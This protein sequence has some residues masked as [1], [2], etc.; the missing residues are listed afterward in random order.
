MMRAGVSISSPPSPPELLERES[1]VK[2]L[3]ILADA[4]LAAQ[5]F[6]AMVEGPPGIGKTSLLA[7][8]AS[9][10]SR[11]G[12]TPLRARGVELEQEFSFGVALQLLDP[13][14]RRASA[15][16]RDELF[17]DAAGVVRRLFQPETAAQ[18]AGSYDDFA[19][20]HGLYWLVAGLSEHSPLLVVVDDLQWADRPSL[21]FLAFLA[22]RLDGLRVAV[23][24]AGRTGAGTEEDELRAQL[25]MTSRFVLRPQ[26]LSATAVANL[27]RRQL[28][29]VDPALYDACAAATGGNPF[30]V[31]ALVEE[32]AASQSPV[33]AASVEQ[34]SPRIVSG[35]LLRRLAALPASALAVARAA[36]VLGDG[37]T[38]HEVATV[39][40][41]DAEAA[42]GAAAAL[43]QTE[44]LV[45]GNRLSYTHP[46]ARN[47][48]YQDLPE[49][50]RTRLHAIAAQVLRERGARVRQV[51]AQVLL[52]GPG[53]IPDAVGILE[54]AAEEALARGAPEVA[55]TYLRRTL[56]E[57]I[58]AL[59]R[60][61][62][63]G[64]LGQAA[65]RAG[66][67]DAEEAL[68]A[69]VELAQTA[70]QH[71]AAALDLARLNTSRGSSRE[72]IDVLT[73]CAQRCALAAPDLLNRLRAE[74]MAI[75][76]VDLVVRDR[77]EAA[78]AALPAGP[79]DVDPTVR[80]M[81]LAHMATQA[82]RLCRSADEAAQLARS[83]LEG[84][85]LVA[86]GIA[87]VQLSFLAAYFLICADRFAEA[88]GVFGSMLLAAHRAG[89]PAGFASASAWRSYGY[90]RQGNLLAAE[91]DAR[92]ALD[93]ARA[94]GLKLVEHTALTTLCWTL[95][96]RGE[97]DE[98]TRVMDQAP[99]NLNSLQTF[100]A[101][102]VLDARGR[103]RIARRDLEGGIA[104][105]AEAGRRITDVGLDNP[106]S[107][108]W[109]SAM[110]VG[111]AKMGRMTEALATAREE[112]EL[113]RRWG[114]PRTLGPAL[115]VEGLVTPGATR[116]DRLREAVMVL[117]KSAASLERGRACIDLG[118]TLH[119]AGDSRS[120]R[121]LLL[122]GLELVAPC[123][124]AADARR[125]RAEL[126]AAGG[127][128]RTPARTGREA[129]TP[130]ELR[131][132]SLAA[133]GCSN[134][135]IAQNLF[136]TVKTVEMHLS[137]VYRKL[138]ISSRA[139]LPGL[140]T[141]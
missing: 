100:Q 125:G 66:S 14:V 113:A 11:I 80:A 140:L 127:H 93:T 112:V 64:G 70:E 109:R 106:A 59:R 135:S 8:A 39:A 95:V 120:A 129:L 2:R 87:G 124:A 19:A 130:S 28:G 101:T 47:A 34:A 131:V 75:G 73:T 56:D 98:A 9:A 54:R 16:K 50:E 118:V 123:G 99:V 108:A 46:I 20:L 18:G 29:Q 44:M 5:G 49:H 79:A 84:G 92:A 60:A 77:A 4:A 38:V 96:D 25:A 119:R 91:A 97:A 114:A 132:A 31:R 42:A 105:L 33:T 72:A 83:A 13:V 65:A 134:R 12:V 51:A 139:S 86:A 26:P 22:P 40:G 15:R 74:I 94:T 103:L 57:P 89:S 48:V 24:T 43:V 10:A 82:T 6:L 121:P 17:A 36:A 45:P 90:F 117:E 67:A 71:A 52:S 111:L 88:E 116:I 27:V 55:A 133:E 122:K 69:A 110:A 35:Y 32:L 7:A 126:R 41:L 53:Q 76:D 21:R 141:A 137:S 104:D 58:D 107:F 1:E 61:E 136:V 37:A 30:Y 3:E 102:A 85:A 138:D 81:Q 63:L 23:V 78:L 68:R 115:R 62:L 128:P